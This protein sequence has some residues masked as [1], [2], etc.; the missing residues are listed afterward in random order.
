MQN[1]FLGDTGH[2][3]MVLEAIRKIVGAH[4]GSRA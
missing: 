3:D 2:V 4:Q 1:I